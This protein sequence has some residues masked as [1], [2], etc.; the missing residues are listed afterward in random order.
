M[1]FVFSPT[2]VRQPKRQQARRTPYVG[3]HVVLLLSLIV[4]VAPSAHAQRSPTLKITPTNQNSLAITWKA[5]SATP[6]NDL[7][8]IPQ[9]RLERSPDMNNWTPITAK[10]SASL[11]QTL[12]VLDSNSPTAFYRVQSLIEKEY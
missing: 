9:Y 11:G 4:L 5:Q 1:I 8:I 2:S 7:L 6:T 10:L 3:Y 12:S